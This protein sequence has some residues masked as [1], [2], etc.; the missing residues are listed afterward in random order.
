M[1]TEARSLSLHLGELHLM[2]AAQ[3][4]KFDNQVYFV[5]HTPSDLRYC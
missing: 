3:V 5:R 2:T 4:P 1:L